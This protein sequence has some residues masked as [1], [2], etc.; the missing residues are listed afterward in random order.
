MGS[1]VS[2]LKGDLLS[3]AE[4]KELTAPDEEMFPLEQLQM[5]Q[6]VVRRVLPFLDPYEGAVFVQILDRTIG[7]KKHAAVFSADALFAGDSMY[8]GLARLMDRSRMMKALRSLETRGLIGRVRREHSRIRLFCVNPHVD[9][10][11]LQQSAPARRK[12]IVRAEERRR[13]MV[14]QRDHVVSPQHEMA[15][16]EDPSISHDDTGEVY[17]DNAIREDNL[18]NSTHPEPSAPGARSP[19]DISIEIQRS[20]RRPDV[21]P[22]PRRRTSAL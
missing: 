3:S 17:R 1:H 12:S 10:D 8:G 9:A 13:R 15:S 16:R 18:E 20:V 14:S 5:Y 6:H 7:W 22:R 21:T 19:L 11:T 4:V 2:G